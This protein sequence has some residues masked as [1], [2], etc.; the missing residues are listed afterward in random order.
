MWCDD[1]PFK[2]DALNIKPLHEKPLNAICPYEFS[3]L[4]QTDIHR[5]I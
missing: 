4:H 1:I 5:M 3:S 2:Q